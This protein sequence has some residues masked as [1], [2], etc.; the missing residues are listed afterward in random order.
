MA[1]L[2]AVSGY[3]FF[4]FPQQTAIKRKP[5][6]KKLPFRISLNTS[7]I[8]AYKLEADKQIEMVS[9][10]G[11]DGIELWMRDIVAF[12]EKGGSLE[13]LREQ[14]QA[15]KLVLENIIG[16]SLWCSD[17]AEERKNALAQ[18][19]KEMVITAALGGRYI[20]APVMGI[21]SLDPAKYG[22]YTSR[23]LSILSLGE[24]T[25]VIP[26]LEI[27]GAGA[28]HRLSDCAQIVIGSG[29]PDATMLLDF[30]HLYRGG[31]AWDALN[32]LNGQRLPVI[33]MNDYPAV[34][35]RESLTDGHRVLPGEGIC[36]FDTILPKLY[37]A[38]FRGGLSVELFNKEYW[39]SMD[40]TTL[41]KSS[42][43]KSYQVVKNA[44]SK[45]IGPF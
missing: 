45:A 1:S 24:E 12:L 27:W 4:P 7:T 16:F 39:G 29:H 19:E 34:P 17:D 10:A 2:A 5:E 26:V 42:Y 38:G 21:Q 6:N 40:A 35:P 32:C 37:E 31:N 36:P 8:S 28:L 15:G 20:A 44:L 43:D 30:Y 23:Y 22:E 11:F 25:G 14:L 9:T 18:L 41:L 13:S 33:H 3:A